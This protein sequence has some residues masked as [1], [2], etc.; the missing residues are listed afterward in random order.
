MTAIHDTAI[1][2]GDAELHESVIVG[3]YSV[4]EAGVQIG[5]HTEIGP[6]CVIKGPTTI[7]ERNRIFQF[8]SIGEEPQDKK[9]AG[10]ETRLVIG[11]GNTIR[12]YCTLN[13]GTTQDECVTTLGD[14]N[15]LMAYVHIAHDCRVGN[16]AIFAN[17]VTLAGHVDVGDY[18]IFGGFSG[19]HQFCRVGA[20]AFVAN[21]CAVTRD[22]PPFVMAAGQPA[23]PRGINSEGLKRRGFTTQQ[24]R[25]IK[26]AFRLMYRADLRLDEARQ[27]ISE[28][29]AQ[30]DELA[31][32]AE[33]IES[34]ERSFIR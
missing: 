2:S 17:N 33:F 25:N 34:S 8:S 16:E 4:I 29:A 18:V 26:D 20:H 14:N 30:Q 12:E 5:A 9:Y 15:W 6:H 22:V 24:I 10:E 3:P 27:K 19:V 23:V 31:I 7:G 11:N 28:A 21:N 32:F 13:R 1:V